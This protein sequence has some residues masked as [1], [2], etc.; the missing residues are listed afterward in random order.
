MSSENKE[1]QGQGTSYLFD[2]LR[3]LINVVDELRDVGL[4][5][6]IRLPRI[7]VV[8]SQSSGKSS[9]LENIVG[10]DFL[11][12]GSGVVTR[13]PL[14]LR[15]VRVPEN[16]QKIKPYAIFEND[17][18]IKYEDFDKVRQ[19]IEF[20][21]DQ[22]AGKKKA[23]VNDPIIMTVYSNDCLDLTLIDLPGI[24]RI[25]LKDSDQSVNVEQ[26]TKEM[27]MHYIKDDRTIILCVVPGNQDISN[28]DGLQLAREVDKEGNR[29]VGVITKLDIMDKGTNARRSLLGQDIQ[30]KL[31]FIGVVNRSQQD[32]D[33]RIRVQKALEEENKFFQKHPVYST[34]DPKYLGT[35]SLTTKLKIKEKIKECEDRLNELGPS[36]P[37][38]NKEKMQMIWTLITEFVDNYRNSIKGKYDQKRTTIHK[39]LSGGSVIRMM[40]NELYEDLVQKGYRATREYTD[41]DI[42]TGIQLHQGDSIPGFPSIDAFLYLINPQLEKLREP[43][44]ECLQ[45][46]YSYLEGLANKILKKTFERFP[47]VL[48]TIIEITSRVL[49]NLRDEAKVVISNVIDQEQGYL[50]TNDINYLQQRTNMIPNQEPAVAQPNSQQQQNNSNQQQQQQQQK[51]VSSAD[52]EKAFINELRQRVDNYFSILVRNVRDT[53]PKSIGFFLVKASQDQLQFQLYNELLRNEESLNSIAEPPSVAEERESIRKTMEVLNNAAKVIKRDPELQPRISDK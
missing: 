52:I 6:Y 26:L 35:K 11:P 19:Q 17:K 4:Q 1:E 23:I 16:I 27:A 29:T 31:G 20:L 47:F 45:K 49:Q 40:F 39:E 32:I 14:E 18:K 10:L 21:T 50:F 53:I 38:Q 25:P 12:R 3:R 48:E 36:L 28:S 15:L 34:M 2:N 5:E 24:T 33:N 37:R 51:Q 41:N 9:L 22:V 13:R 30:L 42:K 43:A 8:G 46:I 44:Y 7:A